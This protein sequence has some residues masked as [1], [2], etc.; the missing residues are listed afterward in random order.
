M[1]AIVVL[2]LVLVAL[3]GVTA[4]RVQAQGPDTLQVPS[5]YLTI[6]SAMNSASTGDLILVSDADAFHPDSAYAD[7]F[8]VK[9]GVRVVA[10]SGQTPIIDGGSLRGTAVDFA[11]R[12][13]AGAPSLERTCRARC[14][15]PL[16]V[17]P[18]C[19]RKT[20]EPGRPR[21]YK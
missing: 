7:T 19:Q 21:D 1:K 9:S 15:D 16:G 10:K 4:T 20:L 18:N 8:T 12:S 2:V 14:A 6:H 11:P 5:Y 13:D 17:F 3:S